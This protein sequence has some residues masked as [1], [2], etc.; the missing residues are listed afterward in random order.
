MRALALDWSLDGPVGE[1]FLVLSAAAGLVY[2]LAANV[3]SRRDRRR[4]TWPRGRTACFLAGLAVLVVDLYSGI[5]TEAD[6]RLSIH[7][8]EHM[9]MW[10]VVAPLLAAGAPVRLAFFALPRPN[11]RALARWL[12]SRGVSAVTGPVGS[13]SLFTAVLLISHLPVVY[14]LAL[15]NDYVH[16]AE[17]GL[18]LL[19]ALLVWA[20]LL[21]VDPLPHR[22]GPRG[23]LVCMGAC[24]L[25][26]ALIALWLGTAPDPVYSHYLHTLGPAALRDQRVAATIMWAG[27]LPA[28]GVPAL[29][30]VRTL[31]GRR[32]MRMRSQRAAA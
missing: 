21:G 17:H 7:M 20:P 24:M 19:T 29:G 31:W 11:R 8:V 26:M 14:G 13:V 3:G 18:Y 22:L 1:A 4:R 12:H 16:E 10:V 32:P 2:L 15:R 30:H 25:P 23:R 6:T 9:V 28:F 5:G 27:C